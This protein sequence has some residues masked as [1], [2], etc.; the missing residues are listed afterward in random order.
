M[1]SRATASELEHFGY[2][3]TKISARSAAAVSQADRYAG[4]RGVLKSIGGLDLRG[5]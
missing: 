3:G 4:H 1:P 2:A 5:C